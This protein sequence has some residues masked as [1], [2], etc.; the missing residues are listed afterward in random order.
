MAR[1]IMF[2]V[3]INAKIK[4]DFLE[5]VYKE[6][7][8]TCQIIEALM[9]AWVEGRKAVP[10]TGLNQSK[11]ITV[12]QYFQR[13]LK[14]GGRRDF[15][16]A[17]P[18]ANFYNADGTVWQYVDVPAEELNVNGHAAGCGCSECRH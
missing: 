16:P 14:R 3:K 18:V 8:S 10:A 1:R 9:V 12:N 13:F 11:T 2:G 6:G 5:A 17:V 4:R 15:S 7:L